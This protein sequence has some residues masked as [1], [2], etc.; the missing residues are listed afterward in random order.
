MKAWTAIL[1]AFS[2]MDL[3]ICRSCRS[4]IACISMTHTLRG[5]GLHNA[6]TRL[7]DKGEVSTSC[8]GKGIQ[9]RNHGPYAVACMIYHCHSEFTIDR[10]NILPVPSNGIDV[11]H[12]VSLESDH[13]RFQRVAGGRQ[14]L[15]PLSCPPPSQD[16]GLLKCPL[17]FTFFV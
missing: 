9:L 14:L 2:L 3:T 6:C 5:T 16:D 11:K 8:P 4:L 7:L 15:L 12:K 1:T 10:T 13:G 17:S